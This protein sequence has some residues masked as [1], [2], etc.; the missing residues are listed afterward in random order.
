MFFGKEK[1]CAGIGIAQ[2]HQKS[3][4]RVEVGALSERQEEPVLIP[5]GDSR[6]MKVEHLTLNEIC[7]DRIFVPC[8]REGSDLM[9]TGKKECLKSSASLG[10]VLIVS[11][12][13]LIRDFLGQI[14]KLHGY[15]CEYLEE[16]PKAIMEQAWKGFDALFIES[17]S[18]E[19]V[20]RGMRSGISHSSGSPMVVV[21][22]DLPPSDINGF[23][24]VLKKPLDYRQ[25]GRL[26]EECLSLKMH[27][28][29]SQ[30]N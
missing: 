11:K 3:V 15:D 23:F 10:R 26:M 7:L 13:H 6:M 4:D 27:R 5:N 8:L 24:R 12:D 22:G 1:F 29:A 2:T 30:G 17:H 18:L 25:M 20:K 21:L 14:L 9:R 19:H 28:R 16:L